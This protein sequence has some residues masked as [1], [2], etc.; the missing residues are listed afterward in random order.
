MPPQTIALALGASIYPPAVA[1]VIA[2]GRGSEVRS[3]VFVFVLAAAS[4]TYASGALTLLLLSGLGATGSR[5][6]AP[7]ATIDLAL[8]VILILVAILLRRR[9]R[10]PPK[11]GRDSKIERYLQSRRLAFVLGVVLYGLP[12]PVYLGAVKGIADAKLSTAGELL[13]LAVTV[14]LMLW[15]I[16]LPMLMLLTVPD[17][18][19]SELERINAWFAR[20]GRRLVVLACFAAGAYLI[21]RGFVDLPG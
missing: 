21:V 10:T 14:V 19:S 3:R 9:W 4:A 15:L 20:H 8:G 12:S 16:E 5:H 17:R 18:A 11:P 13:A 6:R 2:L 7:S 1:A